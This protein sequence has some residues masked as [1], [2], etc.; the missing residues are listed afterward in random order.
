MY[1]HDSN[2]ILTHPLKTRQGAEIKRTWMIL[3]DQLA[4]R[5]VPPKIYI[6]DNEASS[7]LKKA[8]LKYKLR[9][10]LTPPHM[11]RINAAERAIRTFKNH[12]LSGLSA[13]DLTVGRVGGQSFLYFGLHIDYV[14]EH[15]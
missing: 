13:V 8:I 1:D 10:Q 5:G 15:N 6:M 2:A 11:H 4:R 9:Y 3:H 7:D 12:F 14:S